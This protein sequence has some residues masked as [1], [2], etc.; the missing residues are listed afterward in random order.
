MPNEGFRDGRG[1]VGAGEGDG[2]LALV[3]PEAVGDLVAEK[4]GG[5][6]VDGGDAAEAGDVHFDGVRDDRAEA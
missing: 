4:L 2:D 5:G 6:V 3:T 1:D